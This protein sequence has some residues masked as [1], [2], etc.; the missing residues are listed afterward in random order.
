M[1]LT[2]VVFLTLS[3]TYICSSTYTYPL[4]CQR[5]NF[6]LLCF[7]LPSTSLPAIYISSVLYSLRRQLEAP[8]V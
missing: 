3:L 8:H 5:V 4:C 6:V 7:T 1:F 2:L